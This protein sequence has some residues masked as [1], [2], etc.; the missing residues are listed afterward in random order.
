[1]ER[2]QAF[3][4]NIVYPPAD[5]S[6]AISGRCHGDMKFITRNVRTV[7]TVASDFRTNADE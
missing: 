6:R 2:M 7:R 5:R 4:A 3:Q 1:V